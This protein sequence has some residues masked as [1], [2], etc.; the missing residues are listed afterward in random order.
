[1]EEQ[2]HSESG[3]GNCFRNV[4]VLLATDVNKQNDQLFMPN[5]IE[6]TQIKK[7]D[8]GQYVSGIKFFDYMSEEDVNERI[9]SHFPNLENQRYIYNCLVFHYFRI[10]PY[11][12]ECYMRY[13]NYIQIMWWYYISKQG[14]I[15]D[16]K[17]TMGISVY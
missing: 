12:S 11:L 7:K 16:T 10:L 9:L 5:T 13:T 2:S 14:K 4:T 6:M 3:E 15:T 17:Q 8:K 1:M